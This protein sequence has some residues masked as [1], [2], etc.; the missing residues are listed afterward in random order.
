MVLLVFNVQMVVVDS[1]LQGSVKLSYTN[2]KSMRLEHNNQSLHI[3]FIHFTFTHLTEVAKIVSESVRI[4]SSILLHYTI[5][6]L[7]F[8]LV[9]VRSLVCGKITFKRDFRDYLLL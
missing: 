6:S 3:S 1:A 5:H 9:L 8:K 7:D 4:S 2:L